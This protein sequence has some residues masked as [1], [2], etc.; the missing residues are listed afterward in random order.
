MGETSVLREAARQQLDAVAQRGQTRRRW[1]AQGPTAAQQVVGVP[2]QE[3]QKMRL[4]CSNDYLGLASHPVLVDAMVEGTRAHGVGSGASHLVSGHHQ[5]H[6]DLEA[7]FGRWFAPWVA[8]P[9]ALGFSTGYMANLAVI[10]G[11]AALA[12]R[13]EVAI[14]SDELNHASLIDACRLS[15]AMVHRV[16]HVDLA[17]LDRALARSPARVKLI[18][19]DGVF[20]MDGDIAPVAELLAL[21][22]RHDAWLILDDAHGLGVLGDQGRGTVEHALGARPNPAPTDRLILVVTLGK[23][24]GAAGALVVAHEELIEALLQTARPYIFTTAS[25]PALAVAVQAAL[26]LIESP[27]GQRRRAHLKALITR[28]RQGIGDL[29]A[30]HPELDWTL[31]PSDTPIQPLVVCHNERAVALS[32]AL[33]AQ[34]LRVPAI[35]PPTV[36]PGSARLRI[37]LSADHQFDDVGALL[38]GLDQACRLVQST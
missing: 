3:P 24:V 7:T 19:S 35:R 26:S 33:Q 20:S 37:T 29:L 21:A 31:L 32:Q 14:F 10:T 18:V 8:Q 25:P 5:A 16:S 13:D 15:K 17:E 38:A 4:F 12:P 36:A 30:R 23:A 34:G 1:T 11:L 28:W 27:E 9:Q 6:D 2:G 22:E